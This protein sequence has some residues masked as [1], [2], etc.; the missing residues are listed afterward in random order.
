LRCVCIGCAMTGASAAT[1][2]RTWLQTRGYSW[3]TPRRIRALTVAAMCGATVYASVG[4]SGATPPA[5]NR[6]GP[7]HY[8]RSTYAADARPSISSTRTLPSVSPTQTLE[9]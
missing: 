2:L 7:P 1:G 9:R 8:G 5:A 3:L 6:P 4:F